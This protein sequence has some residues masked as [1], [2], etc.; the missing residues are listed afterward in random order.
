MSQ[1]K[2]PHDLLCRK[3]LG[4]R[5]NA[6][7]FLQHYLPRAVLDA[8]DLNSVEIEKDSFITDEL[9]EYFSDLL[10]KVRFE[11]QPGYIYALIEHKSYSE[12]HIGLQ[13]IEYMLQCWKVKKREKQPLPIILPIIIYHGQEKWKGGQ[14]FADAFPPHLWLCNAIFPIF[15]FFSTTCKNIKTGISLASHRSR[16]CLCCSNTSKTR[17]SRKYSGKSCNCSPGKAMSIWII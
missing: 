10:Y 11:K 17:T 16:L 5:K 6:R 2:N 13:L 14:S 4:N 8:I 15:A 1:L 12:K 9:Q 3:T 7:S